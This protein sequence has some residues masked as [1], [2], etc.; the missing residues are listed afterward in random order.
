MRLLAM[1]CIPHIF[2]IDI[3]NLNKSYFTISSSETDPTLCQNMKERISGARLSEFLL[4]ES[5]LPLETFLFLIE[6]FNMSEGG[7]DTIFEEIIEPSMKI[8]YSKKV[9]GECI[10][11][12]ESLSN[13]NP[14][15]NYSAK[16]EILRLLDAF[17]NFSTKIDMKG[18]KLTKALQKRNKLFD[19]DASKIS[20]DL[21]RE[22]SRDLKEAVRD[23][24]NEEIVNI[25]DVKDIKKKNDKYVK[26]VKALRRVIIETENLTKAINRELREFVYEFVSKVSV[27]ETKDFID[28]KTLFNL[29]GTIFAPNI[30]LQIARDM[31]TVDRD[32]LLERAVKQILAP[33]VKL[34]LYIRHKSNVEK[35]EEIVKFMLACLAKKNSIFYDEIDDAFKARSTVLNLYFK[36]EDLKLTENILEQIDKYQESF[37]TNLKEKVVK[38]N[39]DVL[40]NFIIVNDDVIKKYTAF[41]GNGTKENESSLMKIF[42]NKL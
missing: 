37:A 5:I 34:E 39:E 27:P 18:K 29:G 23:M 9:I 21:Y 16:T 28:T 7:I 3:T 32:K 14:D 13:I 8:I 41:I 26:L 30:F 35:K 25:L 22:N 4:Y 33:I 42:A 24:K 12:K 20:I 10:E 19:E 38:M 6:I 17:S 11:K 15:P 40:A 1:L 2:A 36:N 31:F